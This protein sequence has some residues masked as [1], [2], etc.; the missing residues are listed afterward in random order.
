VSFPPAFLSVFVGFR[1]WCSRGTIDRGPHQRRPARAR[2][3]VFSP[4]TIRAALVPNVRSVWPTLRPIP[5]TLLSISRRRDA[6][7]VSIAR[8]ARV[9]GVDGRRIEQ[10]SAFV[11]DYTVVRPEDHG[12]PW[13]PTTKWHRRLFA[14]EV[15]GWS[16]EWVLLRQ[17]RP[18]ATRWMSIRSIG[19]HLCDDRQARRS[20]PLSTDGG[21]TWT[22][23]SIRARTERTPTSPRCTR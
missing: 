1:Q 5:A 13:L 11:V 6:F 4:H 8:S 19:A 17:S 16:G 14:H 15:P 20:A 10:G 2:R 23:R 7:V 3:T 22:A 12:R 18:E 9:I 21:L